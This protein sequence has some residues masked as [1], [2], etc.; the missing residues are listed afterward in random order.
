MS[1]ANVDVSDSSFV[2]LW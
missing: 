1:I 2:L